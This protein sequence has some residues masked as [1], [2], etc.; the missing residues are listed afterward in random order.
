[1]ES[2]SSNDFILKYLKKKN[3]QNTESDQI[4]ISDFFFEPFVGNFDFALSL[5]VISNY[6]QGIHDAGGNCEDYYDGENSSG[7]TYSGY[8]HGSKNLK[9]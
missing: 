3:N 8:S 5:Y 6:V 9:K 1:M 7:T 4:E 2:S